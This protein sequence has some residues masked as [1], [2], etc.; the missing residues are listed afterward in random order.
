MLYALLD[1]GGDTYAVDTAQIEAIIPCIA[2]KHVPEAPP[3]VVGIANFH[4][5]PI[6]IVDC[7]ILL[8]Q[9][10]SPLRYSTRI[11]VCNIQLNGYP[12]KIGLLAEN[13]TQVKRLAED[14]FVP[15]GV[16]SKTASYV[17]DVAN[18]DGRWIQRIDPASIL[19]LDVIDALTLEV[20][21]QS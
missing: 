15:P 10:P 21:V 13:A 18:V 6:V 5:S 19:S 1:A 12:R 9:S 4:G 14:D 8:I 16:L 2:V 3:A 17:G 7:G 11:L 20:E